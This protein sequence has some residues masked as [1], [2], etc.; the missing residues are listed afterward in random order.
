MRSGNIFPNKFNRPNTSKAIPNIGCP[1]KTKKI[2]PA[3]HPVARTFLGWKKYA[4]VR[5]GPIVRGIPI[6]NKIFPS[7][8]RALLKK[9]EIPNRVI[10]IP[11]P[12]QEKPTLRLAAGSI[13]GRF[14]LLGRKDEEDFFFEA[15]FRDC[16]Y[17]V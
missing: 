1:A 15:D 16:S 10:A 6:K 3:R 17:H 5:A 14:T 9:S 12:K 2:P 11:D 13:P 7:R 8:R 4:M